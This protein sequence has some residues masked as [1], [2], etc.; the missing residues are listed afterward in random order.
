MK[1]RTADTT[2]IAIHVDLKGLLFRPAYFEPLMQDLAGQGINT[3]LVEY[4]DIFPFKG[5]DITYARGDRWSPAT[6]SRFLAA[7][8]QNGI[9]VI[10]LQQCLGHLEYLFRWNRYRKF[11]ENHAYPGTLCLSNPAGKALVADL[12]CQIMT[13]HPDSRYVH[14]GMD[15]AH[16]LA[17]CPKCK[18]KGDVLTV[19]LDYLDEL[20]DVCEANGKTP[21][22]WT[23]MLEDHF[24]PGLFNRFRNRVIMAPWDYA[25]HGPVDHTVRFS[26][27]RTSRRW[28]DHADDP[29]AP[30]LGA[31]TPFIEDLP[32]PLTAVIQRYRKGDGYQPI[33]PARLWTDL[34]FRV[35]GASVVRASGHLAVMPNYNHIRSN[36]RTWSGIIRQTRQFGVVGTSWARGTTFCPP[37]FNPDLTWP[38][39]HYLASQMGA[40]P[41]PFWPGIPPATVDRLI[42]QIGRCRTDWRIEPSVIKEMTAR[43]PKLRAHRHEWDSLL[44][45]VKVLAWYRRA[46]YALLEV[47]F[48]HAN[49]RP[50]D[51]EWQRR[52]DD[53]AGILRDMA[54]LRREVRAHFGKRYQGDAFNEWC[55]DLFDLWERK[56]KHCAQESKRKL[57]V[58]ARQY[59][60]R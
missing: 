12:L 56:L 33:Y 27:H 28:L 9:E 57:R 43:R 36:I 19:F 60:L 17:T 31:G 35:F 45:M 53:Q 32:K 54:A 16:K 58:A 29:A 7:A 5:L 8:K 14:L 40:H 34:G 48:F 25:A 2:R 39:I 15:E 59:A 51:S 3:V 26:G 37:G 20:C 18:R 13:A 52:I 4:E 49:N 38:N 10:P 30:T 6:L 41:K 1:A 44:L 42:T 21:I 11:A 50:V 24:R 55:H 23:D 47:E 46:D 22:I